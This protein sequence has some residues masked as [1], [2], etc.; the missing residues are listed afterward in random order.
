[1]LPV[2]EDGRL[3]DPLLRENFIERVFAYRRVRELFSG[4]WTV[5]ALVKFHASEKLLLMAH[6]DYKPLGQ[7]VAR[8]K[9]MPRRELKEEYQR[10]FLTVLGRR[11]T[12]RKHVNVL[13]HIAGYFRK[14]LDQESRDEVHDL[15]EAYRAG[16]VPLIVPVTL[17][18]HHIRHHSINYLADQSA[19][20]RDPKRQWVRLD[21]EDTASIEEALVGCDATLF[22]VHGMGQGG[23]YPEREA[24]SAENFVTAAEARDVRRIVYLG[25]VLPAG[26][27]ASKHL[28]SRRKTGE[29]LRAGKPSTIELRAAMIIGEGSASWMMVKDLAARLPAM[30]LP[31]WLRNCSYPLAID[32]VI[33]GLLAALYYPGNDSRVYELPGPE[34]ISHR[35]VL[36]RVAALLGHTRLMLNVPVLS[37]RLSSY[38]IALVTRVNL[39]LAKELVEGVRYDLEPQDDVL[40]D[41]ISHTPLTLEDAARF[42][43]AA[44]GFEIG[45]CP[46]TISRMRA[47]GSAFGEELPWSGSASPP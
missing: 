12:T 16:L 2:E 5:G 8:A 1:L 27:R 32:D 21:V 6:G 17:M 37:P 35:D 7:L 28:G 46:E 3:N 23:D 30:L 34:K 31:R 13:Q 11:S 25:G 9:S 19:R 44:E 22:L 47:I 24:R 33:W 10:L 29:L 20:G 43:L 14:Q 15:I 40:W 18:R 41:Q 4:R 39:D 45:A 38:W 26:G 42:A 36:R